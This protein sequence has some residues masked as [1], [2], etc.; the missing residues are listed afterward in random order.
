M[1]QKI[2]FYRYADQSDFKLSLSIDNADQLPEI[3]STSNGFSFEEK[4][5]TFFKINFS[6]GIHSEIFNIVTPENSFEDENDFHFFISYISPTSRKRKTIELAKSDDISLNEI[7]YFDGDILI[8]PNEW[9]GYI[10]FTGFAV[11]KKSRRE[12][13][14]FLTDKHSI[15]GNSQ[16]FTIYIDPIEKFD[17]SEIEMDD[18]QIPQKNA[19]YQLIQSN[20]PKIMINEDA[21]EFTLKM[22]RHKGSGDRRALI[23]DTLFAPILVD[24]WEQL[25][26]AGIYKMLPDSDYGGEVIS[27]NDLAK[28]YNS[29]VLDAAK[30][31]YSDA[32]DPKQALIDELEEDPQTVINERLHQAV[33][34]IGDLNKYYEKCAK[35]YWRDV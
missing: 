25:A 17:G 34:V 31:M 35:V 5:K 26:R 7:K 13:K 3:N 15:V 28:P 4:P 20:P 23:R 10:S 22:L 16:E 18:G 33:Q 30:K 6:L 12:A 24:V 19:L 29:I 21:P 14:G 11:R 2:R 32:D 8:D 27:P 1:T 9:F